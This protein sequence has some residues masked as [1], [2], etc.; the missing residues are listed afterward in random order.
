MKKKIGN[1]MSSSWGQR[2]TILVI[3]MVVMA[4]AEPKFFLPSNFSSIFLAI[5]IYGI[6][7]CGMLFAV[8]VGG[9]DLSMG[10]MA[11]LTATIMAQM[12]IKYNAS[13]GGFLLAF[14]ISMACCV[15][16]GVL[17]GVLVTKGGIPPFVVTLATKYL[18]Y[19][20]VLLITNSSYVYMTERTGLAFIIGNARPFGI[21][22]PIII[23]AIVII[24]TIFVLNF[25]VYGRRLYA[26][27]GNMTA[28]DYVGIKS[29]R[30][31]IVAFVVSSV[32]AGIGGMVL[33][34][35]NMVA[36]S[37]TA[38]GYEGDVLMAM[39]V[40]GINLAGGEG[41]VMGAVYGALL[42]GIINNVMVLLNI[43]FDYQ[44]FVKGIVIIAALALNIYTARRSQGLTGK[45][46]FKWHKTASEAPAKTKE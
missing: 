17:H 45:P 22:M 23:F 27:G 40:G 10:S 41:G 31:V 7:A 8:L 1:F 36:G 46:K 35:M 18:L 19:G 21:P 37:G 33:G 25:T 43:P 44:D 13:N 30:N 15:A 24:A 14:V 5:S 28:A 38:G 9:M 16:V 12:T 29:K 4:I 3:V 32:A 11:A 42:V 2:V 39:I 34:S 26:V 20:M 6:M